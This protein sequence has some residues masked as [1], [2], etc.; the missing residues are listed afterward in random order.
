M[1]KNFLNCMQFPFCEVAPVVAVCFSVVALP[2][3]AQDVNPAAVNGKANAAKATAGDS[4]VPVANVGQDEKKAREAFFGSEIFPLIDSSKIAIKEKRFSDAVASLNKAKMKLNSDAAG[5]SDFVS[6]IKTRVDSMI[7]SAQHAWAEK[8]LADARREYFDAISASKTKDRDTMIDEFEKIKAKA[9]HSK[10][11]YYVGSSSMKGH[12]GEVDTYVKNDTGF[13]QRV[14]ALTK[15][16]DKMIKSLRFKD[17]T[18]LKTIDPA[19]EVRVDKINVLLRNAEV[20][21]KNQRYDQARETL[22][23]VLVMDPYNMRATTQLKK[24]YRKLYDIASLRSQNEY[25]EA[26]AQTEWNFVEAVLPSHKI[27]PK[28]APKERPAGDSSLY[29]KLQNLIVESIEFDNVLIRDAIKHLVA[30]SIDSDPEGNGVNIVLKESKE[31]NDLRTSSLTLSKIPLYH[32]IRYLCADVG[33]KFTVDRN[34]VYIGN[35]DDETELRFFTVSAN[36]M[37]SILPEDGSAKETEEKSGDYSASGDFGGIKPSELFKAGG[38]AAKAALMST[39]RADSETM[40]A[41]FKNL[42]VEFGEKSAI[43]YDRRSNKLIVNNTPDNLRRLEAR[44]ADLDVPRPLVLV[45]SKILEM[46]MDDIEELGFHWLLTYTPQ[47]NG[48]T[49][50]MASPVPDSAY[51]NNTLINGLNLFP[52]FGKNNA[53]NLS[54]TVDAIDRTSR[55]EILST[56]KVLAASGSP[57]TIRVVEEMYFPESWT[58]PETSTS[59]G[60]SLSFEPSYPEFGEAEDIGVVF[61][62]TPEVSPNN[63]TITLNLNPEVKALVGWSDYSYEIVIGP[64]RDP[65]GKNKVTLK[66]PEISRRGVETNVKVY[67]GETVVLG[68]MMN[69]KQSLTDNGWPILQDIPLIGRLFKSQSIDIKKNNLMISVTARLMGEDG[70]PVRTSTGNGLPEFPR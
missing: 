50:A 54:L 27:I 62:V 64:F 19:K 63:Y 11:V 22:E 28:E 3:T 45:E 69:D 12:D 39:S 49:W 70:V 7:L 4:V 5:N 31:N 24:I 14:D 1:K 8:L 23:M 40:K 25:L 35:M 67:D 36:F 59:N 56:P 38:A 55:A 13:S 53:F 68:G 32:V 57:A 21:A 60:S 47:A 33:L 16:I 42:G 46:Q 66:M 30:T 26:I 52:N 20:Q 61:T 65:E 2:L 29:D 43:A 48:A 15:Q 44:L 37:K 41:F 9:Q 10:M 17:E 51:S 34:T 58:E 6:G 18:S